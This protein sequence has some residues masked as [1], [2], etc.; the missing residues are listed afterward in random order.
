M[1]NW[2]SADDAGLPARSRVRTGRRTMAID[3]TAGKSY[4]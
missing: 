3:R 2:Y 1:A 4:K